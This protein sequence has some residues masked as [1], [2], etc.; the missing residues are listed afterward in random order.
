MG[1]PDGGGRY[2][3][4]I[5][6]TCRIEGHSCRGFCNLRVTKTGGA[7]TLD[8]HVTGACVIELDERAA[9][10]LRDVLTEWLG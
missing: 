3:R 1:F 7:I 10:T 8:P 9:T 2:R 4:T 6:V 5:P